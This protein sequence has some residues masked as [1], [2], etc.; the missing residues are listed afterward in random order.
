[1]GVQLIGL[2]DSGSTSTILGRDSIPL[3][4]RLG[5]KIEPFRGRIKT[6]DGT[7]HSV[8]GKIMIPIKYEKVTRDMSVLV[9]PTLTRQL[10]LGWD[11]WR[12]F[13]V[14]P[15]FVES[16]QLDHKT[17][18]EHAH[19]LNCDELQMLSDTISCFSVSQ[20]G[21]IGKTAMLK[22]N[23]DTGS[24]EPIK[25]RPYT[26]SPYKEA[27]M[28]PE[29]ERMLS[30]G[31]IEPSHSPWCNPLVVVKKANGKPRLCLD[32]RKLNA[33]TKKDAFPL[34]HI[35][36]ILGRLNG[37]CYLSAIDLS[38]AFWQIELSET[39]KEKTAFHAPGRGL[40]QF[41]RMPFGLHNAAQTLSRL[42]DR[43]LRSDLEPSVFVYLDDII[44]MSGTFEA[45]IKLL[46]TVAERLKSAGLTISLDKSKFC[47]KQLR[48]LG[49]LI[50]KDG[51]SPDPEKLQGINS[52]PT[53]KSITETRRLLGMAGWYRRFIPN[54]ATIVAP[55]T[56]LLKKKKEV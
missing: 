29:L 13:R 45:H 22:H 49:Y 47:L 20:D 43:V 28:H 24:A 8:I 48:Y 16:V 36:R 14:S 56:D 40:Y 31:V 52:F 46:K 15:I 7:G 19:A 12:L 35:A 25:Q 51:V 53:P 41:T 34:P 3:I 39:S 50:N 23:I 18:V 1:M 21:E 55:I 38:D 6:A 11:F 30:L 27:E 10:I 33:V 5:L 4:R 54:F 44:V 2:L 9:I 37:T 17:F 32:S 42:M 26:M